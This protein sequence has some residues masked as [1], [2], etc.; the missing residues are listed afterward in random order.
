VKNKDMMAAVK[1]GLIRKTHDALDC[2]L[3][4]GTLHRDPEMQKRSHE[5]PVV[6]FYQQTNGQP[7]MG[8]RP[9]H[10]ILSEMNDEE[11]AELRLRVKKKLKA[12]YNL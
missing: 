9:T 5:K 2:L 12:M 1:V 6:I 7:V 4:M 10:M 8:Q 11:R 3:I